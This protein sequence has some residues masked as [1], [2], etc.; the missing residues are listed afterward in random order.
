MYL[1]V[2]FRHK[3]VEH[4]II[5]KFLYVYKRAKKMSFIIYMPVGRIIIFH[6]KFSK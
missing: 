3:Q 1:T 6:V 2:R 5:V 4:V